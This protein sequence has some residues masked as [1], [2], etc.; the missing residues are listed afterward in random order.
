MTL[1]YFQKLCKNKQLRRTLEKGV[2]VAQRSSDHTDFLLFQLNLF[3]IELSFFY[4]SDEVAAV[5]SF[6]SGEKLDTYLAAID[7]N[8]LA[9][10]C[11]FLTPER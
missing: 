7:L 2:W 4:E 5:C 9:Y 8:E 6:A 11:S 1:K 10:D 3:Y